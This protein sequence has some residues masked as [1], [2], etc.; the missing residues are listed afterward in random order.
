MIGIQV[1]RNEPVT[2]GIFLTVPSSEIRLSQ[3]RRFHAFPR[4][5]HWDEFGS[6]LNCW[7]WQRLPSFFPERRLLVF[8]VSQPVT[9]ISC[10]IG[11]FD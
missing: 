4:R 11:F 1:E 10:F 9:I 6:R 7:S 2:N 8:Q 3:C 5:N